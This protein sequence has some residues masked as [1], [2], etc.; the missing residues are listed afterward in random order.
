MF[1]GDILSSRL[2]T[3]C[4]A[5]TRLMYVTLLFL[6]FSLPIVTMG[7][8]LTALIAT[9]RQPEFGTFPTF[10][11]AFATN[12]LRSLVVSAFTVFSIIFSEQI[13]FWTL[14]IP[15]G[16]VVYAIALIFLIV[17]NLNAYL[18]VSIL[19]K[20][21]LTFFRQV[22]FF[23]IGTFYKTFLIPL[24]GVGLGILS[25]IVGGLPMLLMSISVLLGLYVRMIRK[26]LEVVE[27]H[28]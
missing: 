10:W 20:C 11:R 23:T 12:F 8:A 17:Y 7:P 24:M 28:L 14:G 27:E 3:I 5:V 15:M 18:F 9:L 22:F 4:N 6:L 13:R 26:D 19:K 25:P 16:N 21:N 1:S 2:Y